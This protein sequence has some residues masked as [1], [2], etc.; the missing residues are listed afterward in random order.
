MKFM[1]KIS[2][3]LAVVL[4]FT[5]SMSTQIFAAETATQDG[6]KATLTTDKDKYEIGDKV[7]VTVTVE[8][9][10]TEAIDGVSYKITLPGNL[11]AV[12]GSV[13]EYE[14]GTIAA[15]ESK[16]ATVDTTATK[17]SQTG[18][19]TTA[20]I[21]VACVVAAGAFAFAFK[22]KN[23]KA[24]V[25]TAVVI[26]STLA[27]AGT[28]VAVRAAVV[29]KSFEISKEILIGK[30]D[31]TISATIKYKG[32][33]EEETTTVTEETTTPDDDKK[34]EDTTGRVSV[35]DPSIIKDEASGTY[36][37]F[38]SHL[39][40]AKSTDLVNWTTFT[41]N[42][43]KDYRTI[44][45]DAFDWANNGDTVYDPSGNMWAPDVVYNKELGKWTMYMSING[46]SWNSSIVMLT[47][48][49]LDGDWTYVGP[50]VYSGFTASGTYALSGTDFEK[51]TGS[52]TLDA[53]YTMPAYTCK[54]GNTACASTTWNRRYG[55]H[56]IDPCVFYDDN[57]NLYMT[58]GSWSGG[59][60][61]LELDENTGLR[62]YTKKYDYTANTSDPY[63]GV[64]I[65]DG[66]GSTG[67]ASYVQKI[68]DYYYLFI[69]YG[70]LAAKGGYN[71]KVYRSESATGPYVDETGD[72]A[73]FTSAYVDTNGTRGNRLMTYY[74]WSGMKFAQVAQGHNSAFVDSDGK[75]Y[76][77]YHTRTNDGSEG[78]SV[79]VHQL[80][81][82][83]DGWLVAA[84]YEYSGETLSSSAYTV[85]DVT[86]SYDVLV[87]KKDID[88]ANLKYVS[89]QTIELKGNGAI[90]G[91]LTGA[92]TLD[93]AKPYITLTIDGVAYKGVLVN[94]KVEGKTNKTLC[95]TALG[96]NEIAIWGSMNEAGMQPLIMQ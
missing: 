1:K 58:Y 75:A 39:A 74:K 13:L 18:D 8:N 59:I 55:A 49:S 52:T 82:N 62:D 78:H 9:T 26:L 28:A 77:V 80:F 36:Y 53:R 54:D 46:C 42:I 7:K 66:F 69:T 50:V 67:E 31:A 32:E 3:I 63:M 45:A 21:I 64:K 47:A 90:T 4:I 6:L 96:S 30:N 85:D 60:Y 51:A 57:G 5:A 94:Q 17:S 88:Y 95:F 79:R 65:A 27:V 35:H 44:F 84:P 72:A 15:G 29:D 41:N 86:G 19:Y 83:A 33:A 93:S 37:I 40:W 11:E 70:G 92:W 76:V 81:T 87:H 12:E 71:M 25:T 24:I 89:P 14:F 73:N 43:N 16:E 61:I 34:D 10:T 48:N 91:E 20:G 56:A 2:A 22:K 23:K 68:G 38:G